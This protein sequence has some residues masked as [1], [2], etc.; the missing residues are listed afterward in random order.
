VAWNQAIYKI[1]EKR[2]RQEFCRALEENNFQF[3]VAIV[4]VIVIIPIAFGVPAVA[5]FV[6]PF[7]IGIPAILAGF[8]QFMASVLG[9]LTIPA[10]V[11]RGF[12]E[13]VVGLCE[14]VLAFSFISARTRCSGEHE[15]TGQ[16]GGH[17][18]LL[19]PGMVQ[20]VSHID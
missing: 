8:P 20:G 19:P 12:M 5:V 2:A 1:E 3:L 14:A 15:K 11:L 7:V 18:R 10:V 6:P 13:A 17:E 4:V 9:L 16:G